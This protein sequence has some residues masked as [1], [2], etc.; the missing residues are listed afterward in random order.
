MLANDPQASSL[1]PLLQ[2]REKQRQLDAR[3]RCHWSAGTMGGLRFPPPPT[4]NLLISSSPTAASKL[5]PWLEMYLPIVSAQKLHCILP[6]GGRHCFLPVT[7][8][9]QQ[10]ATEPWKLLISDSMKQR[11][12][13]YLT[14]GHPQLQERGV[15]PT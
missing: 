9:N 3:T 2:A 13:W 8:L 11:S 15:I 7:N 12:T 6:Q 4:P 1:A 14:L 10:C 5:R